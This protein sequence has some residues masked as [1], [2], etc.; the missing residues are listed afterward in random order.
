V[1][2]GFREEVIGIRLDEVISPGGY[3]PGHTHT[4]SAFIYAT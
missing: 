1:P 3:S 2:D 4:D